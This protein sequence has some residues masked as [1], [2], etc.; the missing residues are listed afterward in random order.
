MASPSDL[1]QLILELINRARWEPEAEAGRLGIGLNDGLGGGAIGS[2]PKQPLAFD[3]DLIDAARA[4]SDWMLATDSFSHIGAGGSSA[5]DRMEDAGYDFSGSW[6]WGENIAWSGTTGSLNRAAT[7]ARLHDNLFR[8]PGHRENLME[9]GFREIGLGEREGQFT[10]D[11]TTYNALMLTEKFARSGSAHFLTGVVHSDGDGDGFY[12]P[13]DGQGGVSVSVGG[14]GGSTWESGGYSVAIPGSGGIEVSFSGGGLS[15]TVIAELGGTNAKLDIL[16][17]DTVAT[18]TG[19]E[20]V[21]GL[22]DVRHLGLFGG[23]SA[24]DAGANLMTGAGGADALAGGGGDDTLEGGAGADTLEGGAGDDVLRGGTGQDRALFALASTA[25][26]VADLGGALELS[27]EGT[28]RVEGDVETFV[29][30]DGTLSRAEVAALA[31]SV[32]APA[33]DPGGDPGNAGGGYGGDPGT[34]PG[35]APAPEPG[36]GPAPEP[37]NRAPT[38]I[39]LAAPAEVTEN[40]AAGTIVATLDALDPDAGDSHAFRIL[41]EQSGGGAALFEVDGDRLRVS[42]GAALDHEAAEEHALA[43]EVRDG[44]GLTA[45]ET[46][47]VSVLDAPVTEIRLFSGGAVREDAAPGQ[48]VARVEALEPGGVAEPAAG[49]ALADDAGGRFTLDDGGRLRL[50]APLDFEAAESHEIVVVADGLRETFAIEVIDV[51]E[52]PGWTDALPAALAFSVAEDAVPGTE[53]G[54]LPALEGVAYRLAGGDGAPIALEGTTLVVAGAAALDHET[55]PR[56]DLEVIASDG[57]GTERRLPLE[58]AVEDAPGLVLDGTDGAEALA[59]GPEDDTLEGAGGDD[60]LDGGAG[61]D[62]LRG[63]A[64][65]DLF[66]AGEGFDFGAGDLGDDTAALPGA[67]ADYTVARGADGL[68]EVRGAGG[69]GIR[70]SGLERLDFADGDLLLGLGGEMLEAAYR[71]YAAAFA[72]TPDGPGLLYWAGRMEEGGLAPR[73]AALAFV[74]SG[75]F[76]AR[77]GTEPSDEAFV[78]ALYRNVLKRGADDSGFEFW[79]GHFAAG[80]HDRAGMLLEFAGS[81][82]NLER[83]APDL[84]HGAWVMNEDALL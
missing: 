19:V 9:N 70:A 76:A 2:G 82:E 8:S 22:S 3:S 30:A 41:A 69:E 71:L 60:T 58:L 15:A 45:V 72:R 47:T 40:A 75:E 23:S 53:I 43:V 18:T 12:D 24:G 27:G 13:G 73:D 16:G 14:A 54:R 61:D 37:A 6:S 56:L 42:E 1:E 74:E 50:A 33:P 36:S 38:G 51:D 34:D 17:G 46:V 68:L 77:Y 25:Y 57:A 39:A 10:A 35:T 11:G 4:H 52:T 80:T 65:D 28:D 26:A 79:L 67:R 21:A 20:L 44:E 66:R 83:T 49:L 32:P 62:I 84:E 29:F 48:L 81:P 5:G 59:G 31:G 63:G 7:A 55:A 64:G 78:D